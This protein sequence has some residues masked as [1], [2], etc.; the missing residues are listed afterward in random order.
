MGA[1]YSC[2]WLAI[3]SRAYPQ[4]LTPAS[5]SIQ[6]NLV[7]SLSLS[8]FCPFS[9]SFLLHLYMLLVALLFSSLFVC[10]SYLNLPFLSNLL[11]WATLIPGYFGPLNS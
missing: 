3:I 4:F 11:D 1:V 9:F 6:C 2:I 5:W 8:R 7:I 10:F